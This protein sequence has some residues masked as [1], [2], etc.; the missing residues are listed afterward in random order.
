MS[1]LGS[2]PKT[3]TYKLRHSCT[4]FSWCS[5]VTNFANSKGVRYIYSACLKTSCTSYQY[6]SSSRKRGRGGGTS[7]M[8]HIVVTDQRVRIRNMLLRSMCIMTTRLHSLA[9]SLIKHLKVV[10]GQAFIHGTPVLLHGQRYETV[11]D[12]ASSSHQ[13]SLSE[14]DPINSRVSSKASAYLSL[15]LSQSVSQNPLGMPLGFQSTSMYSSSRVI[16][17]SSAYGSTLLHRSVRSNVRTTDDR[18]YLKTFKKVK[19]PSRNRTS[20]RTIQVAY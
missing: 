19:N 10:C 8:A 5:Y 16:H 18:F 3:C 9:G 20:W 11:G 17:V 14:L 6:V 13:H 4:Q 7:M 12:V 2:V 15:V 1:F